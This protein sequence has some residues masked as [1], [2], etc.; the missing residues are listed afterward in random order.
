MLKCTGRESLFVMALTSQSYHEPLRKICQKKGFV[1][2][3]VKRSVIIRNKHGIYELPYQLPNGLK[4]ILHWT[5]CSEISRRPRVFL[6]LHMRKSFVYWNSPE[7]SIPLK[8][9]NHFNFSAP[10]KCRVLLKPII[11]VYSCK[12]SEPL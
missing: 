8:S 3:Q 7:I 9:R 10:K 5:E 2:R 6:L 12:Q 11:F 4:V 1:S